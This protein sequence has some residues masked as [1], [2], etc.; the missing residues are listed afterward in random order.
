MSKTDALRVNDYLAHIV[1]AIDRID[2]YVDDMTELSFLSDE[3]TQD[4][5]VRNFEI[6]GEAA[7]SIEKQHPAYAK[8]HADVPWTL[9]YTIRNRVAHGY[10]KVDYELVWKTIHAD[11][12]EL[13]AQ[14]AALI[15]ASEI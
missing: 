13:R 8:A 11:L 6:L 2:R 14:V 1:E 7:N 3:K 5:V 9:V 12:P 4:A 15:D 10:F